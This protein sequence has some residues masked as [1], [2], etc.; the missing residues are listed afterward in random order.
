MDV[1]HLNTL[2]SMLTALQCMVALLMLVCSATAITT[3]QNHL[4]Q[5]QSEDDVTPAAKNERQYCM[6]AAH[7]VEAAFKRLGCCCCCCCCCC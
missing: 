5:V 1:V 2:I 4:S 3:K 6:A 7:P